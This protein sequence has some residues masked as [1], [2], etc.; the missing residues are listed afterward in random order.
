MVR[1]DK[2]FGIFPTNLKNSSD[3]HAELW[4]CRC[5]EQLLF[6]GSMKCMTSKG[7]PFWVF[8]RHC[9]IS[10]FLFVKRN[11]LQDFN[12]EKPKL[13]SFFR[14]S[15]HWIFFG[16]VGFFK[17]SLENSILV[18]SIIDSWRFLSPKQGSDLRHSRFVYLYSST[19]FKQATNINE[20]WIDSN[21][22]PHE[23]TGPIARIR[24]FH[25]K[26]LPFDWYRWPN[27]KLISRQSDSDSL[28]SHYITRF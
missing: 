18:C 16:A 8:P 5:I 19:Y 14:I 3:R 11:P 12:V 13:P 27:R 21:E 23:F 24:T 9:A 25:A 22:A 4:K 28:N 20:R 2:M 1:C 6:E 26:V 15:P 17:V 10:N 7:L